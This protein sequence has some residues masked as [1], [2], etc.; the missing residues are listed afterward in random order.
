MFR[1]R[2]HL[3]RWAARVLLVW[4]MSLGVTVA[5]ACLRSGPAASA[6]FAAAALQA[7]L[8]M[9]ALAAAPVALAD[10]DAGTA[11]MAAMATCDQAHG[12][13]GAPGQANC[14]DFCDKAATAMPPLKSLLDDIQPHALWLAVASPVPAPPICEP[15]IP[16]E[17]SR[18]SKH[19]PPLTIVF[20][21][22]V[23]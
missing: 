3:R 8:A 1:H 6:P 10:A 12:Q 14:Q 4:L 17:P 9:D 20:L 7:S 2:L 15:Q 11:D 18:D 22:L 16:S 23:L 21:R 19:A 5:H 13:A